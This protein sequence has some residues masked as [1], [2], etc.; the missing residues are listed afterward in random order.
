MNPVLARNSPVETTGTANDE[1][2]SV[3]CTLR[4]ALPPS[5]R[6]VPTFARH[7][8]ARGRRG[9][10]SVRARVSRLRG[11]RPFADFEPATFGTEAEEAAAAETDDTDGLGELLTAERARSVQAAVSA[12]PERYRVPLALAYFADA[13]YDEIALQL[14]IT[15]THVATLLCRAKQALRKTLAKE[16][17]S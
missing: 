13:G 5:T 4:N 8:R 6:P 15:R 10:G 11:L 2:G 1:G 16:I 9:A 17:A 14:G 3:C 12:L 7:W